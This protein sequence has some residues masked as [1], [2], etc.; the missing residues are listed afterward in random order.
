MKKIFCFLTFFVCSLGAGQVTPIDSTTLTPLTA[1][2]VGTNPSAIAVGT[3]YAFVV[4]TASNTVTAINLSTFATTT[5]TVAA[6]PIGVVIGTTY[7]FILHGGSPSS[8]NPIDQTTL[9][10]FPAFTIGNNA[11]AIAVGPPRPGPQQ[12]TFIVNTGSNT[13]T[14]LDIDGLQPVAPIAV[15]PSPVAVAVGNSLAYVVN[16]DNSV[17]PIDLDTLTAGAAI[18]TGGVNLTKVTTFNVG[19]TDYAIVLDNGGNQVFPIIGITLQPNTGV[20]LN[21]VDI[22]MLP[23]GPGSEP[24]AIVLNN[25][26]GSFTGISLLG[27]G[28]PSSTMTIGGSPTNLAVGTNY[29]FFTDPTNN[30]VYVADSFFSP[31]SSISINNPGAIGVSGTSNAFVVSTAATPIF[32]PSNFF[33]FQNSVKSLFQTDLVNI[34]T[35]RPPQTGIA[36]FYKIFRDSNLQDLAGIVNGNEFRF[37]DHSRKSGSTNNYF[38][39]SVDLSGNVSAPVSLT[40]H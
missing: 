19:G 9:A 5:L 38:I 17:T 26:D 4:N 21:P 13:V 30:Q 27:P 29:M 3:T 23:L 34:L 11:T 32:P 37:V 31:Q 1:V 8:V 2:T 10:N 33:G 22:Q 14:V 36:A 25:G 15:G 40:I 20:G 39:V 24:Y 16:G 18:A 35:W 6:N 7:A 12:Y 28:F